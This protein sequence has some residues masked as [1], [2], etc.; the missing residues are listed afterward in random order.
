MRNSVSNGMNA[1]SISDIT[2]LWRRSL[3]QWPDGRADS[4]TSVRWMQSLRQFIDLRQPAAR[5]SFDDVGC[6]RELHRTHIE[7]LALQEGFAGEICFDGIY[8]EWQRHIDLQPM[9]GYPD[10]GRLWFEDDMMIEEGR[11]IPYIEH[12]HHEIRSPEPCVGISLQEVETGRAGIMVRAGDAFMYARARPLE[13]PPRM[14]LLQHV[15]TVQVLQEAQDLIDCEIS[16]G[17]IENERWRIEHSSLPFKEQQV[18]N[19]VTPGLVD[20]ELRSA[21]LAPDGAVIERRWQITRIQ[22]AMSEMLGSGP[23]EPHR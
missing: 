13:L 5:P 19:P 17:R 22:G 15:K 21:D 2:G 1:P 6:L 7:W 16:F 20:A 8:F 3:I 11:D 18:L 14:N 9:T 12:W 23:N 10:V 4:T